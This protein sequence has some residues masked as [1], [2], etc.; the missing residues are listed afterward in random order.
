M[1]LKEIKAHKWAR[2][3]RTL[4]RV[5]GHPRGNILEHRPLHMYVDAQTFTGKQKFNPEGQINFWRL[6]GAAGNV[7][8]TKRKEA[9]RYAQEILDGHHP[10]VESGLREYS[11]ECDLMDESMGIDRGLGTTVDTDF[12]DYDDSAYY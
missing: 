11:H 10:L 4:Y 3:G 1:R 2:S 7:W 9:E 12:C 8:F 6:N 5:W